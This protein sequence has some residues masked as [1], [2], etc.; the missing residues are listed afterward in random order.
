MR[1]HKIFNLRKTKL[2]GNHTKLSWEHSPAGGRKILQR[3][4][5]RLDRW[6]K[7]KG[8]RFNKIKCYVQHFSH[9]LRHCYR[10]AEEWL[11]RHSAQKDLSMLNVSQCVPRGTRRPGLQ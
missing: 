5:E 2:P 7:T 9:N 11:K 10:L 4:M 8:M 6:A 1:N 3:D